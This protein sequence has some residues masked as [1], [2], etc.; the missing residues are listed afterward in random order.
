MVTETIRSHG[1]V[2]Y[3]KGTKLKEGVVASRGVDVKDTEENEGV[4]TSRGAGAGTA[5]GGGGAEG[6]RFILRED[7]ASRGGSAD[8]YP[9]T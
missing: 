3:R 6:V 5:A 4:E 7:G 2:W 9:E 8:I 1:T